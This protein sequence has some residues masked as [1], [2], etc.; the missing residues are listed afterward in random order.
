M[1]AVIAPAAAKPVMN[2]VTNPPRASSP[3]TADPRALRLEPARSAPVVEQRRAVDGTR[4][5]Y[6]SD[7]D[8][9]VAAVVLRMHGTIDPG[10]RRVE[11]G[12]ACHFTAECNPLEFPV[13]A[14]GREEASNAFC[15]VREDAD[16]ERAGGYDAVVGV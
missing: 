11:H 7:E 15:V 16:G 2:G 9:V 14:V 1:A 8:R 12:G 3:R 4:G 6:A 13:G 10:E 5:D